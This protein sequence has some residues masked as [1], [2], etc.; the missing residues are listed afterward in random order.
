VFGR[1]STGASVVGARRVAERPG[2]DA[3]IVT[4]AVDTEF[5]HLSVSGYGDA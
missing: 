2:P 4:L 3:V 5:K 1:I